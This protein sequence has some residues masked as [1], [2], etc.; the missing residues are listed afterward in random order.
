MRINSN[1]LPFLFLLSFTEGA[2]VMSAELIG[3]K[4]LAP[5]FGSSLYVWATIM[6]MT[7]G[8]LA[9]GYFSGGFFAEKNKQNNFLFYIV[10]L[11]SAFIML[12]PVTSALLVNVTKGL[13]ILPSIIFSAF[14]LL[15][16]PVFFMGMVSPLIIERLSYNGYHAGRASGTIYAVSTVGGIIIT[17]VMG[18]YIIPT[19][20]LK[21]PAYIT[22]LCLAVFPLL[23]FLN[24]PKKVL[25]VVLLF[26]GLG[27]FILKNDSF[28]SDI[29]VLYNEEGMLGQIMVVDYPVYE[30]NNY[31]QPHDYIRMMMFNRIIQ[32]IYRPN[33]STNKYFPYADILINESAHQLKGGKALLLGLGGGCVAN[34][35][36][37]H[38][39]DVDAVELDERVSIAAKKYFDLNPKVKVYIDDARR[40]LNHSNQQYDL[41][42][43]DVFKGEENPTHIITSESLEIIKKSLTS[44]GLIV[45]NGYGFKTGNKSLGMKA[46]AKTILHAGFKINIIS[47]S[48]HE[49]QGNLLI[50]AALNPFSTLH[51]SF[52]FSPQELSPLPVLTDNIPQLEVLNKEAAIAWRNSYIA[53]AITDFNQRN[54]PLFK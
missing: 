5:Y 21:L 44:N 29:K 52:V 20:G 4:M 1:S 49:E 40:F 11:A 19:Y 24:Q 3:A 13:S 18:F 27:Y 47:S 25:S 9:L 35:L 14:L 41:I 22:G 45:L 53:T 42:V 37:N 30:N 28:N 6:A 39:F 15:L 34:E 31:N 2:A 51:N 36:V 12:M 48:E 33:S 32:T 50:F 17:F 43:F 8:G 10:L 16:P 38:N 26:I 46:I 23:A 7:L 54:V